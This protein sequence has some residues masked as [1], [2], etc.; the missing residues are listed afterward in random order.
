MVVI[1]GKDIIHYRLFIFITV[2]SLVI[3]Y[4]LVMIEIIIVVCV[5]Y[6]W[7]CLRAMEPCGIRVIVCV[8]CMGV[9]PR[10]GAWVEIGGSFMEF[11]LLPIPILGSGPQAFSKCSYTPKTILLIFFKKYFKNYTLSIYFWECAIVCGHMKIRGQLV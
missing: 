4:I 11:I 5:W 6:L 9:H 3:F 7:G 10:Y 2:T 1:E 8:M